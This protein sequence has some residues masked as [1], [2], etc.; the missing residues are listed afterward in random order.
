[1]RFDFRGGSA[2]SRG[3]GPGDCECLTIDLSLVDSLLSLG[4]LLVGGS[5]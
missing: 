1:M 2:W 4:I 5:P 3:I